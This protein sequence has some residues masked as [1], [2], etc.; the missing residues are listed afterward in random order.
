MQENMIIDCLKLEVA[1]KHCFKM[2]KCL[3]IVYHFAQI[4]LDLAIS[5]RR[6]GSFYLIMV[7]FCYGSLI[8]CNFCSPYFPLTNMKCHEYL[9]SEQNECWE[10]K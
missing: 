8:N 4:F 5:F 1:K 9:H 6:V 10:I 2:L 3:K 7:A